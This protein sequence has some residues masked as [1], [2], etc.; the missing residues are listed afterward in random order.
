[1][2]YP[3]RLQSVLV[4]FSALSIWGCSSAPVEQ[5]KRSAA[6]RE[7]AR[8]EHAEEFA[9][10]DWSAAEQAWNSAQEMLSQK[11]YGDANQLLLKAQTRFTRA[12]DIA[13]GRRADTIREITGLHKTIDFRSKTLHEDI[14]RYK[15]RL[16]VANQKLLED[17]CKSVEDNAAKVLAQLDKGQYRDAKLLAQTTLRQVWEAEKDLQKY[18]GVKK[19]S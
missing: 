13:K 15:G 8:S 6:E 17:S 16:S 4:L 11:K 2:K 18:M 12:H 10:E 9:P 19:A 1:M 3:H 5:L 14:D 7:Q